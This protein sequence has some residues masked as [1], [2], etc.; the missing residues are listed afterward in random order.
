MQDSRTSKPYTYIEAGFNRFYNRSISASA[1]SSSLT[2]VSNDAGTQ[3][4]NFD[5]F[6]TSGSLGDKIQVGGITIDG[7]NRRIVIQDE[8][9]VEIGWIGNLDGS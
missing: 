6:Q 5:Q 8:F 3:M 9:G 7:E 1:N 2:Q 4:I